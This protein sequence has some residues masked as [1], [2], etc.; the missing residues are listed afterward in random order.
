MAIFSSSHRHVRV[1]PLAGSLLAAICILARQPPTSATGA[2]AHAVRAAADPSCAVSELKKNETGG[3]VV[4][5]PD[6]KRY[7][8]NKEDA[9]G[10]AQIYLGSVGSAELTC[11]TCTQQL[12]GPKPNR[13]KM[14][15][16]WHPDGKWIVLAAERDEYSPPPVLGWSRKYVEGQLQN[17]LWTNMYAV[18][19]DGLRWHQLTDFKTGPSGTPNGYTGPAFTRDGKRAVWSQAVD[20]NILRYWPFGRW[21]MILADFD[22]AADVPRFTNLRNITPRGM[23]WNEPGTFGDNTHLLLSVSAEKDA[24]GMDQLVLNVDTGELRNLT[25]SPTV[26]DEHGKFSPDSQRILFMSAYPYRRDPN[27]SKAIS[28]RTEFMLMNSD[29]SALTQLTHFREPGYPEYSKKG[30]IAASFEWS[31]D[32]RSAS[33]ARLFF[34]DYEYWTVRF[35]GPCGNRA[36]P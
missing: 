24:Q 13:F 28:I 32:G 7:L 33:L 29:G 18:S 5:S 9:K 27:A 25:Q 19:P 17:G 3:M 30:G 21:E 22:G 16:H 36:A 4:P 10:V 31:L 23:N 34:P 35:A 14:Q 11:L 15:P 20:G 8:V 2:S 12:H 1:R 26:W 6:G